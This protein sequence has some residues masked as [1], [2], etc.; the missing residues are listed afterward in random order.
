[1]PHNQNKKPI[2][3]DYV[4][5]AFPAIIPKIR[6]QYRSRGRGVSSEEHRGRTWNPD[7]S[8]RKKDDIEQAR[9]WMMTQRKGSSPEVIDH[10]DEYVQTLDLQP[11][12]ASDEEY[13]EYSEDFDPERGDSYFD[14]V[15]GGPYEEGYNP[16]Q[17]SSLDSLEVRRQDQADEYEAS[18][19]DF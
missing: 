14:E 19:G 2:V 15:F 17:D 11:T 3:C 12:Q 7:R 16:G 18:Q 6:N 5:K 13:S 1:M 8:H 4:G 10:D 9:D